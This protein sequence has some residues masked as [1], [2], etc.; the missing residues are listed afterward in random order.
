MHDGYD[1]CSGY[2]LNVWSND[3]IHGI[4]VDVVEEV[5]VVIVTTLGNVSSGHV[6]SLIGFFLCFLERRG[7]LSFPQTAPLIF[8][9]IR[10]LD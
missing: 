5:T 3:G 6:R 8:T 2:V 7:K 10:R 9:L 4:V 1:G